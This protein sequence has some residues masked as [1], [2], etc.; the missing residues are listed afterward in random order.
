MLGLTCLALP[1]HG[2][3]VSVFPI[4]GSEAAARLAFSSPG[5]PDD[6]FYA[7]DDDIV[8]APVSL[9]LE[10]N[11]MVTSAVDPDDADDTAELTVSLSDS[12]FTSSSSL[13]LND[14]VGTENVTTFSITNI[15][16]SVDQPVFYTISGSLSWGGN[17]NLAG[18]GLLELTRISDDASLFSE[19]QGSASSP[20]VVG[21]TGSGQLVGALVAGPTY[22]FTADPSLVGLPNG[23][24]KSF[25][26]SANISISFV[27]A[28]DSDADGVADDGDASGVVGDAPC[29]G[30]NQLLCD[31]NCALLP[32]FDQADG[33]ADGVGDVCEGT[34]P[35]VPFMGAAGQVLLVVCVSAVGVVGA[36][37]RR[38]R[39]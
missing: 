8:S 34:P 20:V 6:R 33:D 2:A 3:Q 1:A 31:D 9:P 28:L 23:L 18:W 30:G 27:D 24:A 36:R 5:P 39:A 26:G 19:V 38:L 13:E 14:P 21:A 37:R 17:A 29:L 10:L 15:R 4:S 12:G 22:Q 25:T 11:A 16:F 32:N 35:P 7:D